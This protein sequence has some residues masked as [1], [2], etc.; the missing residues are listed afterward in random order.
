MGQSMC[1]SMNELRDLMPPKERPL[2]PAV[3]HAS[4][5]Q[6]FA[7]MNS[8]LILLKTWSSR[9]SPALMNVLHDYIQKK[10]KTKRKKEAIGNGHVI[11]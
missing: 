8:N 11:F 4:D 1:E 10:W 2:P 6:S 9:P 3:T 5:F 7:C